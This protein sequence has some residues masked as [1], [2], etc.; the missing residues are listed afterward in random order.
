[1]PRPRKPEAERRSR[2]DAL[3]VTEAERAEIEAAARAADM[4]PGR[5][6]VARHRDQA[7]VRARDKARAVV[8]LTEASGKLDLVVQEIADAAP[9]ID[10]VRIT[11]QLVDLER[12]FRRAGLG[13]N[14]VAPA[15]RVEGPGA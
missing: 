1:M 6:L 8:A 7:P 4:P 9:A 15:G 3:Y 13:P 2:W 10:A 12:Q 5:Y 11:A 14:T